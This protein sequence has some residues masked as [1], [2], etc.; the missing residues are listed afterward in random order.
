MEIAPG[1]QAIQIPEE[2]VMRP[3]YTGIYLVGES[4]MIMIDSG[5]DDERFTK[6]ISDYLVGLG[7]RKVTDVVI[8]H[9]H[10]DHSGG[11]KWAKE[12]LGARLW[13][14][15]KALPILEEKLGKGTVEPLEDGHILEAERATLAA[16]YTPGHNQDSIC[17]YM[18]EQGV[19]FTGDTILGVG[20]VTI[21]D[22]YDYMGSLRRLLTLRNLR[23]I[24]PGHG[25]VVENPRKKIREYIDHRNMRDGQ[26]LTALKWGGPQTS[27]QLALKIYWDVD[28]RLHRP[29]E[30][31]VLTHL[32]KLEREG[33]VLVHREWEKQ[34]F[35]L[36]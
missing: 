4:S 19:L 11:L 32:R 28:P 29:A 15:P 12:N 5:E 2:N 25:P 30:G 17:Y 14:H 36:V 31:N 34:V 10:F 22:L 7:S 27:L 24:C 21:G 26:I 3:V 6:A 33:K 20:T 16:I 9:S 13:A 23:F 35:Q 18:K 8:T 1:V